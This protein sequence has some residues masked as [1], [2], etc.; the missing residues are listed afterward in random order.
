MFRRRPTPAP[1]ILPRGRRGWP[2]K[3][4]L[5]AL[6]DACSGRFQK[7]SAACRGRRRSLHGLWARREATDCG[8]A[9]P[10][11]LI[12]RPFDEPAVLPA[13]ISAR[14][15]ESVQ[16]V[17]GGS[18]SSAF[19]TVRTHADSIGPGLCQPARSFGGYAA[20]VL[21]GTPTDRFTSRSVPVPPGGCWICGGL[22]I[23][24]QPHV[25]CS[26]PP[27]SA[28]CAS[29]GLAN[30]LGV[31]DLRASRPGCP[32]DHVHAVRARKQRRQSAWSLTMKTAA[33]FLQRAAISRAVARMA[34][35]SDFLVPVLDG[36]RPPRMRSATQPRGASVCSGSTMTYTPSIAWA[37][38]RR[39]SW[40]RRF[41]QSAQHLDA[42]PRQSA[43]NLP[44]G[45]TCRSRSITATINSCGGQPGRG[46]AR[47]AS[48]RCWKAIRPALCGGGQGQGLTQRL[49]VCGQTDWAGDGV[50]QQ[51]EV[52][53][54]GPACAGGMRCCGVAGKRGSEG[55]IPPAGR[56]FR[57][58]AS[59]ATL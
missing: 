4:G 31:E 6:R 40:L 26:R 3:R 12:A 30:D 14:R 2:G 25:V 52:P 56:G 32:S 57:V 41:G 38:S 21:A 10:D 53:V 22:N 28:S 9:C 19:V 54:D 23:A 37:V 48:P 27:P 39:T 55:E 15:G 33:S 59:S 47:P 50:F 1:G 16:E 43:G 34:L 58:R 24:S 45:A 44:A 36:R 5:T 20:N 29:V 8:L 35:F 51:A 18:G 17:A 7:P 42:R 46:G 11:A 49:Q 13:V